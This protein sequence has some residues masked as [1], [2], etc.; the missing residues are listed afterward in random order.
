MVKPLERD[1]VIFVAGAKTFIGA[2]IQEHLARE[3]YVGLLPAEMEPDLRDADAV[4]EFLQQHTPHYVFVAAGQ[5]AGIAG[6]LRFP[7][8]LMRDNLLVSM[9]VIHASYRAGVQRL[10]Y[11]ASSC[12]YPRACPQP[13]AESALMTGPLESTNAAYATAKL[14]GIE[15]C[16]AYR[17]QFGCDFIVGIPANAFGPGDDFSDEGHVIAAL[18]RRMHEARIANAPS[19]T[20][21]GTGKPRREF[22]FSED[23]A[24]ACLLA[25]QQYDASEPINLG[26]G[27]DV[28]IAELAQ[29]VRDAV[30]YTG[31][32]VFDDT[33]PDGMPVKRL[34]NAR[35]SQLGFETSVDLRDGIAK[36]YTSFVADS[37]AEGKGLTPYATDS[38]RP[39]SR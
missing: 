36:T 32:L 13:M 4:E 14:A 3:G 39:T 6:N 11:L 37:F 10:L 5:T 12:S 23:L 27:Q 28:S 21:W 25:L 35:L 29:L 24:R 26:S 2:A 20:I 31:Q 34:D 30:G 9:N 38:L 33:R 22:I 15:M 18:I 8:E 16:R 1:A 19:V 7:A 17:Q